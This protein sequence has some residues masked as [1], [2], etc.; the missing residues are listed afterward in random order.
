VRLQDQLKEPAALER[1]LRQS[2]SAN[3][4]NLR[5][6]IAAADGLQQTADQSASVHHFANVLFNCMRG[7]TFND[8]YRFPRRDFASF[9]NAHSTTVYASHRQWLEGQPES[10][11]LAQLNQEVAKRNDIH[12]SRLA[13][14]YLPLSFSRRHGDPSRP[15]NR[16]DIHIKDEQGRPLYAYQGNWRDI[17]QNWESLA[18]SYPSGSNK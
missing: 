17:F 5:R 11:T 6:R 10:L 9:I 2:L 7:G 4:N 12:L 15:W 8:S 16:F 18:Q 13:L 3:R 1:S 14:E